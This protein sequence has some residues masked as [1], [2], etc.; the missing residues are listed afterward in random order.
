MLGSKAFAGRNGVGWGTYRPREIFNGGDPSGLVQTIT[1]RSWGKPEAY[2]NGKT[3]IFKPT[4]GYYPGSVNIELRA[5]NLGHCTSSGPLAY[6]H[7]DA[8]VPTKP[9]GR[10]GPWFVWSSAKTLCR[11][12][13]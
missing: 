11:F 13:F 2:G 6:E 8:R 1:W 3:Y 9:G 4:G 7:L 10:L 5:S 12:A